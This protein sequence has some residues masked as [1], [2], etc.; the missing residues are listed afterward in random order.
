MMSMDKGADGFEP[1]PDSGRHLGWFGT[2]SMWLAAN[3]VITTIMTG[4]LMVPD[5][6][7][8]QAVEAMALGSVIGGLL[9]AAIGLIGTR[10]G[11][12]TMHLLRAS[13]GIH[14]ALV[15]ALVNGL[16]LIAWVCIQTYMAAKSIDYAVTAA[17]G[18]SNINFWVIFTQITIVAI[19]VYGM[20]GVERTERIIAI[21]MLVMAV[22]V[23]WKLFTTYSAELLLTLPASAEPAV[24]YA[25]AIDITVATAFSWMV[26]SC[27][28]NRFC[29]SAQRGFWGTWVGYVVSTLVAMGLGA[30]VAG[31]SFISGMERQY[32]PTVLLTTHGF[33]IFSAIVVY[34]SV[35]STNV[36][37]A[38]GATMSF[39]TLVPALSFWKTALALGIVCGLGALL[40]ELLMEGFMTFIL[41]IGTL[42]IP[43]FAVMFFDYFILRGQRYEVEGLANRTSAYRYWGGFNPFAFVAYAAGAGFAYCFTYVQPLAYGA[44]LHTFLITG[45]LYLGLSYLRI[46]RGVVRQT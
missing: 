28:F 31:F 13:F 37:A 25:V 12:P 41:T 19:V 34:L 40:K 3:V 22:A 5:M 9:L 44:S 14:G 36:M 23:F 46:G 20:R 8:L 45:A 30:T 11:L 16:T 32:D 43:V 39:R 24:T 10:T 33:G 38:Y 1:T 21:I 35:L 6:T 26:L 15:P 27:D 42:F 29:R 4:M 18:W 2:F 7:W 17:L